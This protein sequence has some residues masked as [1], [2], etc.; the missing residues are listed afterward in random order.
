MS[1][2][3]SEGKGSSPLKMFV[4]LGFGLPLFYALSVGPAVCCMERG[5]IS[6][7]LYE[8]VFLPL[9]Q[10]VSIWEPLYDVVDEYACFWQ[11]L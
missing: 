10:V 8:T 7:E 6:E 5:L 11:G 1:K 4:M 3:R 2:D 9:T